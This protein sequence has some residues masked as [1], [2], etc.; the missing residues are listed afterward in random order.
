MNTEELLRGELAET[1]DKLRRVSAELGVAL[2][3]V[4]TIEA[5]RAELER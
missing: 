4:Q 5:A 3:R 1:Q 2:K